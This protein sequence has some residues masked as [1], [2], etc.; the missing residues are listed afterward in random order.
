MMKEKK[1]AKKIKSKILSTVFF[2]AFLKCLKLE[3][4]KKLMSNIPLVK[5]D[6]KF[7]IIWDIIILLLIIMFCFEFSVEISFDLAYSGSLVVFFKVVGF[8]LFICDILIK[9]HT[10]FYE[11]GICVKDEKKILQNYVKTMLFYDAISVV[12]YLFSF[13]SSEARFFKIFFLFSYNNIRTIYKNLKEQW[14]TGDFFELILL[15]C[16]LVC[17]CH[18]LACIWHAIGYYTTQDGEN[19]W[20]EN[21][22]NFDWGNRY[23]ISMYWSI[24]TLCTV[25]Y[26]DITP[27]NSIEILYASLVMLLGTLMFGYNINCIGVLIN[28]IEEKGKELSDKINIVDSYLDKSNINETLKLKVKKYLQYICNTED[29]NFEKGQELINKLPANIKDEIFLESIGKFLKGF[30][31][32]IKNF[33]E[34]FVE[35]IALELKPTRYSP[36]DVIY[37]V[38]KLVNFK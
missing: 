36:C 28:K 32:L 19:S 24:T 34:D 13:L 16:R 30:P 8:L 21:Y 35:K 2:L 22:S 4:L 29:K 6:S 3:Y 25:G 11:Y 37:K 26:G 20:I 23:L 5:S 18:F 15:L 12:A 9:T 31:I 27:K 38:I 10:T 17:V 1:L 14:K 7:K 33:S